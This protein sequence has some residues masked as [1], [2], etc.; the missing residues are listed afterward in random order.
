MHKIKGGKTVKDAD[1]FALYRTLGSKVNY[2]RK[3]NGLTQKQL[4]QKTGLS[5]SQISYIECG[6]G[7]YNINALFNIARTLNLDINVFFN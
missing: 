3:L 2:Y 5:C 1:F 7:S 4:S 6:K